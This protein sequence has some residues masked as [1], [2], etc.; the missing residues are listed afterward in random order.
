MTDHASTRA[1]DLTSGFIFYSWCILLRP[2]L[3]DLT[4]DTQCQSAPQPVFGPS[5]F[6]VYI[7]FIAHFSCATSISCV[8]LYFCVISRTLLSCFWART[9]CTEYNTGVSHSTFIFQRPWSHSVA[10][11]V[12]ESASC[13][14]SCV[15]EEFCRKDEIFMDLSIRLCAHNSPPFLSFFP[16]FLLSTQVFEN[17]RTSLT[18]D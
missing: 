8:S 10:L 2:S 6:L 11:S 13:K 17:E 15:S 4:P 16:S 14:P 5:L 18:A 3:I 12:V 7:I 1:F 9:Y